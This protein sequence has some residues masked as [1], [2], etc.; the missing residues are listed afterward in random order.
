MA[1]SS[2]TQPVL[3]M[4]HG[5]PMLADDATWSSE[6]AGWSS[7]M[8]KPQQILMVSA[9][10]EEAPATVSS[11]R[12]DTPLVYDFYGFPSKYYEVEYNTPPATELAQDVLGVLGQDVQQD[13]GR[14]LDH[15][16][17][18]PL[19]EMYPDADIPVL[20]LSLPSLNPVD[21]FEMGQKL[22]P[23]RDAGTL[24]VGSGFTT[25]NLR[26]FNPGLGP[27]TAPP[28]A[29][30]EFDHWAA[31]ALENKDVDALLNFW[32]VAPAAQEAHPRI[33]HWAPLYVALGAASASG[34]ENTSAI[35]GF[36]YGMS[37]RSWQFTS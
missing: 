19:A 13:L 11:T 31:E 25:H 1:A 22:A 32:E 26:W 27:N 30:A 34:F 36:W 8:D 5:A 4:S 16:A 14:G 3:F 6:L 33:E 2:S 28:Q 10:W 18:V 15:G 9:H 23:L 35:E 17:Y 20:Q 7:T 21:L 37:K 24:I 12:A 29:S